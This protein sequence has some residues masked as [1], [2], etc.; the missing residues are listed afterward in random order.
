MAKLDPDNIRNITLLGHSHDGKTSLAEAMLYAG[1]TVDRLGKPDAG[2][3]TFDYE[4]EETKR[5]ISIGTAIAH[6][7]WREHK[8]NVLDTPGFQDFVGEVFGALR[9]AEGALLVVSATSGVVVGTELA[10]EQVRSRNLPTMIVVNK[11][12]KENADFWKSV[13]S[14]KE[15]S[16]RPVAIQAPIGHEADF[17]G[18]VDLVTRK[19]YEF[20][21]HGKPK[22]VPIP[23]EMAAEV[24]SRRSPVVEAA[25]ETDDTLLEKYLETSELSD[26]EVTTALAKGVAEGSIVPVLCTAAT[27]AIGAGS[28]LDEVVRLLPSPRQAP[29]IEAVDPRSEH[30]NQLTADP[31]G[32]LAAIIFKTTADPFV[33]RISYVKVCSGTLTAGTPLVNASKDQPERPGAIGYPKG[34]TLE[35]ATEVVAGDIAGVSKLQFSSTGETLAS[36]DHAFRIPAIEYPTQTFSAAVSAKNKADEEKVN[37]ALVKL[38]D[39]DPTLTLTH[40]PITKE[41]VLQGMGDV[42]LDVVLE[43]MKRKYGVEG[44]TSVPRVPYQE[45]IASSARAEKKYKKQS[46]GA[47]LYGHCVIEIAPVPRGTGFVWEDKIFGGSIPQNFR[48]SVEKGVR[49]TMEQG[50]LTGNPLVDIKVSLLDGSTHAVDGKDIAFKLAGAM[51][52]RQAVMDARP[53]LLEPIMDVEVLVPDRNMGDVISDLN[54][55]RGK[56]AGMEPSGDHLEKVRAQVPLSSMYRFPIDLRS[57]TQGRGRYTMRFSHYEEVPAHAAQGLIAAYQKAKGGEE[58]E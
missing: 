49:E 45:T 18:V 22:E 10:W 16:P 51:A 11:M 4:P 5:K 58:E 52:M 9:A 2:N 25:A 42:H 57:I 31:N 34:K 50:V 8:I 33:G 19:A 30:K 32:P 15:F 29:A 44:A 40:E 53:V 55:K 47:G 13:D 21:E 6:L 37:A 17:R 28:L 41:S 39:E 43:K 20:D 12:D 46:G 56:I 54:G 24:E 36:R 27:K 48:P 7:T 1:G 3:T 26:A 14:L 35:P 23:S 38:V